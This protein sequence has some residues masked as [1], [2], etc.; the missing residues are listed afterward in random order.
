MARVCLRPARGDL[1]FQNLGA[2]RGMIAV[3]QVGNLGGSKDLYVLRGKDGDG[4]GDDG[5]FAAFLSQVAVELSSND[6]GGYVA[7]ASSVEGGDDDGGATPLPP[8]PLSSLVK[9]SGASIGNVALTGYDDAS[10]P[11]S[12]YHSHLDSASSYSGRQTID[13]DAIA[14]AATLLARTAVAAAYQDADY[15]IDYETA[16]AYA[17]GLV[18][19]AVDP[20][21]ETFVNLYGNCE[22]LLNYGGVER[23][24]D[25]K[26]TG[27]DIGM[28]VLLGT[29]PNYYV[30]I[31][32]AYREGVWSAQGRRGRGR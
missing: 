28:G 10:V 26:R 22:T 6:E 5:G 18:Q 30:S 4:D 9:I 7:Q 17:L 8:T 24:N 13:K 31:Y 23:A 14:S 11:M 1:T 3:D 25:A 27:K 2:V 32:D 21:S 29:P 15:S 19:D 12:M 20:S 16:A